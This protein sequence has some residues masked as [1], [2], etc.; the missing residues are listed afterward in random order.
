M[1]HWLELATF[2]SYVRLLSKNISVHDEMYPH[3]PPAKKSCAKKVTEPTRTG[4]NVLLG[5]LIKA[6]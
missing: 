5:H 1:M 3:D 6:S 2:D 4:G